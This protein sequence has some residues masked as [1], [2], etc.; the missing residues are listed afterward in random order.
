MAISA[1]VVIEFRPT[2][3]GGLKK[4]QAS[5][6]RSLLYRFQV[7]GTPTTFGGFLDLDESVGVTAGSGSLHGRITFWAQEAEALLAG[8]L[9]D[10][11]YPVAPVGRGRIESI[12]LPGPGSP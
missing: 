9:F 2:D 7:G 1:R 4:P 6:T 5:G 12:E 8:D 3:Q 11:V 10:I